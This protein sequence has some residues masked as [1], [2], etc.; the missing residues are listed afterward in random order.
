[1]FVVGDIQ[2]KK[3]PRIIHSGNPNCK[4]IGDVLYKDSTICLNRKRKIFD[5]I[6]ELLIKRSKYPGVIWNNQRNKW[7][8]VIY[9]DKHQQRIYGGLYETEKS[10]RDAHNLKLYILRNENKPRKDTTS[11]F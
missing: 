2:D 5:S 3:Y 8:V 6:P 10:A 11:S 7:M 1:M 4:K 9:L